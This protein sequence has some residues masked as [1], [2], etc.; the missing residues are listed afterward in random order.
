MESAIERFRDGSTRLIRPSASTS[1]INRE[2]FP[3]QPTNPSQ[4]RVNN[5]AAVA[6]NLRETWSGPGRPYLI[7]ASRNATAHFRRPCPSHSAVRDD[8]DLLCVAGYDFSHTTQ[9]GFSCRQILNLVRRMGT[10]STL[11]P[12]SVLSSV[13]PAQYFSRCVHSIASPTVG[14]PFLRRRPF[15]Q[16]A[17]ATA[18]AV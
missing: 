8:D 14:V 7:P 4:C 15:S 16:A 5:G 2:R 6:M 17:C 13:A 3:P 1:N 11:H 18:R 9:A 10:L 12:A